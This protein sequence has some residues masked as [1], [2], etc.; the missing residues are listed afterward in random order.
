VPDPVGWTT[1]AGSA[2]AR[3]LVRTL[4]LAPRSVGYALCEAIASTLYR[5]DRRHREIALINLRIAFPGQSDS[6]R[7]GVARESYRQLGRQ[8]V[9][10]G[11]IAYGTREEIASCVD[12]EAGKGLEHYLA[13]KASGEGVLFVTAHISAWELLPAAHCIRGY[14]LSFVVRPLD[15][16]ILDRWATG[17]RERLGNRVIPKR[18]SLRRILKTLG[19]G[20]D[21][22][23]LIDQNVQS[24]E[25]VFAPLFGRPASTTASAAMIALRTGCPII[26]GFMTPGDRRGRYRIRFYPPFR[27]TATGN[28]DADL[29]TNTAS[30]NRYIESVVRDFPHCWLWGHRRFKTQPDG[31]NPYAAL[32]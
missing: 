5:L 18:G 12:Y 28:R 20:K 31:G 24:G 16:P 19:A 25:G 13:A 11:R 21:V 17:I 32:G 15:N 26:P 22:G 23:I 10:L 8:A 2:A 29:V 14:P 30:F 6:W 27:A 7:L 4:A 9:E 3:L 1:Y